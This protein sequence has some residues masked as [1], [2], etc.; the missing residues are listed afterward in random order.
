MNHDHILWPL[1][2]KIIPDISETKDAVAPKGRSHP[3]TQDQ[4][5]FDDGTDQN[6]QSQDEKKQ[7]G[8]DFK[9]IAS[10]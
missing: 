4:P 1:L 10:R 2:N 7:S 3:Y 5:G 6:D 9:V 8:D